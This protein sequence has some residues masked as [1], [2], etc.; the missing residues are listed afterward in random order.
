MKCS[1]VVYHHLK[2]KGTLGDD[3]LYLDE[4]LACDNYPFDEEYLF[5][6]EVQFE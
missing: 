4:F 6:A 1:N 2:H 3:E 5:K